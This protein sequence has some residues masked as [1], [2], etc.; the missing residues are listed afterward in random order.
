MGWGSVVLSG[1]VANGSISSLNLSTEDV[2]GSL[3][4]AR[5][6]PASNEIRC[7]VLFASEMSAAIWTLMAVVNRKI[8]LHGG[9]LLARDY[10]IRRMKR[11]HKDR[12]STLFQA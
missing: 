7:D 4:I 1:W 6:V 5:V 3:S 2:I 9:V 8:E 12:D 11:Y 10:F